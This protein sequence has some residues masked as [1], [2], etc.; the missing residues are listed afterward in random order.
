[1]DL[2]KNPEK[3][4][5]GLWFAIHL[6]AFQARDIKGFED[7]KNFMDTVCSNLKCDKC[8]KHCQIHMDTNP[9]DPYFHKTDTKGN[10]IGAFLWSV[11]FHNSVNIRLGKPIVEYS[12]ARNFYE[13]SAVCM[14]NCDGHTDGPNGNAAGLSPSSS[15][16]LDGPITFRLGSF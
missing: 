3:F 2:L 4:G 8:K 5:P 12:T 14:E 1:M 7:F 11:N 13:N 16:G 15:Y 6:M 9:L 10:L